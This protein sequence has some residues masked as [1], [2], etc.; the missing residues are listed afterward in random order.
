MNVQLRLQM[1][2]QRRSPMGFQKGG[3]KNDDERVLPLINMVFLL[4]IFFHAGR[5]AD[6]GAN[7]N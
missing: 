3:N 4:L 7:K 6:S 5:K 1:R 2:L